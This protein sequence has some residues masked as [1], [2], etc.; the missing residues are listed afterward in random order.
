MDVVSGI[1]T[2]LEGDKVW[3]HGYHISWTQPN[4]IGGPTMCRPTRPKG[5]GQEAHNRG[6][7]ED[8]YTIKS[9]K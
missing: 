2:D 8:N 1:Y 4:R 3:Y 7:L 5:M 6:C 9:Y